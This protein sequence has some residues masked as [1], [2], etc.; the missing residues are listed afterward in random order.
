AYVFTNMAGCPIEPDAFVKRWYGCLR[1][2]GIR[3]RGLYTMKDT[4][5]STALTAG[6]NASWLEAQT[7][8]R[9]DTLK[10]HYGKWLRTEGADQLKKL[11]GLD[12]QLD[13]RDD[14][15]AEVIDIVEENEWRRGESNRPRRETTGSQRMKNQLLSARGLPDIYC[16]FL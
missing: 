10:R 1:V 8:V 7:G 14:D 9:Y 15:D 13:H 4:Y 6:V 12:P 3:I 11:A 5:V 2:L 16:P